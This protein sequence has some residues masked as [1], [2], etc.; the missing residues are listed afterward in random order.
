MHTRAGW[1]KCF[2]SGNFGNKMRY[3]NVIKTGRLWRCRR[4]MTSAGCGTGGVV[5]QEA[6]ARAWA[7]EVWVQVRL[8]PCDSLKPT[9]TFCD[10]N[11]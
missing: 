4:L 8:Q 3:E 5:P 1:E 6:S 7:Y 11:S 9:L 10:W 2:E